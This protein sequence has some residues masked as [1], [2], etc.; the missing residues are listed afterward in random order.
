MMEVEKVIRKIVI[1]CEE[2]FKLKVRRG[3]AF[4]DFL[5]AF[6]KPWNVTK[7]NF[8]FTIEFIGESGIDTGGLS[9]E[10]YSGLYI[11]FRS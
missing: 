10:F 8:K 3:F 6:K 2:N 4:N 7:K 5:K 1:K 9:R 11:L